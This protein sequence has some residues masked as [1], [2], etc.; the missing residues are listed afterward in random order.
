MDFLSKIKQNRFNDAKDGLQK[1]G[2]ALGNLDKRWKEVNDE[3]EHFIGVL[4][5][6]SNTKNNDKLKLIEQLL[7]E[8]DGS[9]KDLGKI[10]QEAGKHFLLKLNNFI[11][12]WN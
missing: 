6:A 12:R 8:S 5:S 1:L 2:A 9:K 10:K 7:K 3:N 11:Y 4:N